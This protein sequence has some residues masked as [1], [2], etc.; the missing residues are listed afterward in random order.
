MAKELT[1]KQSLIT[2][3]LG[4]DSDGR[5]FSGDYEKYAILL[6]SELDEKILEE[7]KEVAKI[8]LTLAANIIYAQSHLEIRREEKEEV[9]EVVPIDVK[10]NQ[11]LI[12]T[13]ISLF[14][15]KSDLHEE[16]MEF[17]MDDQSI[18]N[19]ILPIANREYTL[20]VAEALK[21]NHI[22]KL[23]ID[24]GLIALHDENYYDKKRK[25]LKVILDALKINKSVNKI[26]LSGE[27]DNE[28]AN[29]IAA[30]LF[31]NNSINKISIRNSIGNEGL[32]VILQVLEMRGCATELA[33]SEVTV[34]KA[35]SDRIENIYKINKFLRDYEIP[36]EKGVKIREFLEGKNGSEREIKALLANNTD[37]YVINKMFVFSVKEKSPITWIKALLDAGADPNLRTKHSTPLDLAMYVEDGPLIRAK[38]LVS[39]L[40]EYKADPNMRDHKGKSPLYYVLHDDEMVKV[41]LDNS[42]VRI[43]DLVKELLAEE[44]SYPKTRRLLKKYLTE[45]LEEKSD[46]PSN[47]PEM[48]NGG[49]VKDNSGKKSCVTM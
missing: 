45:N 9:L 38:E 48:P 40:L 20:L 8:A 44:H 29:E 35:M 13:A 41:I 21:Q 31:F 14:S 1:A 28:S 6:L 32:E 42:R 37:P 2:N 10:T 36:E 17:I 11:E 26:I 43:T 47:S 27:I 34:D 3:I 22:N 16:L 39:L 25:T 7:N 33:F 4:L 18:P 49:N 12:K 5:L 30:M 19:I 46:A 24:I 23:D 15:K